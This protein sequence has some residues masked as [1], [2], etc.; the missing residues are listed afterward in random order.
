MRWEFYRSHI[1]NHHSTIT[2]ETSRA[3][4]ITRSPTL[5]KQRSR[6][7]ETLIHVKNWPSAELDRKSSLL[8]RT[9]QRDNNNPYHPYMGP[10][11]TNS[12]LFFICFSSSITLPPSVHHTCRGETIIDN[13]K[14]AE[15]NNKVEHCKFSKQIPNHG[16][17]LV[18]SSHMIGSSS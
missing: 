8:S 2:L 18:F 7:S 9:I 17:S 14:Y 10:L 16:R 12:N 6:T 13:P 15:V 1:E 11:T 3:E 4:N 5:D